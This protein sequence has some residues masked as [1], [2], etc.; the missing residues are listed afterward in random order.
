MQVSLRRH[1]RFIVPSA[2][3]RDS[4]FGRLNVAPNVLRSLD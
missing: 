3:L 1:R 2:L 4:N